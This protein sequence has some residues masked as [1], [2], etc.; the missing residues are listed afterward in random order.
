MKAAILSRQV[1]KANAAKV[2]EMLERL[3]QLSPDEIKVL[4]NE[5]RADVYE[6]SE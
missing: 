1:G 3:T 5:G 2:G 4:L 6:Y